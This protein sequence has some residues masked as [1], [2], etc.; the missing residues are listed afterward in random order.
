MEVQL[1]VQVDTVMERFRSAVP[2]ELPPGVGGDLVVEP[3]R[4]GVNLEGPRI[5]LVRPEV[6]AIRLVARIDPELLP[7]PGEARR[8]PVDILDAPGLV[9]TRATEDSVTIRRPG[10]ADATP[11]GGE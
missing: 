7:G 10:G 6:D 2:V 11:G 3:A 5:L 9:R 8:V 1:R 4:L